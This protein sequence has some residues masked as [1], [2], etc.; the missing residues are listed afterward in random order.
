MEAGRVADGLFLERT[1]RFAP[2][3]RA[4]E[5]VRRA[6]RLAQIEPG[7]RVADLGC[8]YGR[9]LRALAGQGHEHPLGID[10]SALL[11]A[12]ARA[13]AEGARLLRADLRALPLPAG[14]PAAAFCFYSSM[15]MGSED[16]ALAA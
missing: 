4:G 12:E 9:H 15:F 14:S 11:I 1:G 16:D 13:Q 10:R 6:L 7:K 8:G 2:A 5:D 3:G